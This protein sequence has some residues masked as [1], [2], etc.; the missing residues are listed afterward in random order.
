MD[1]SYRPLK[2][3]EREL[4]EKLLEPDFPGRDELLGQISSV[5]AKEIDEDGG[6]AL[7]C[8]PSRPAPVK[9]RVPTE[10]ECVDAD[11]VAIHVLL[12]VVDG[13]MSELEIFKDDS[14]RV[15]NPPVA[16]DLVLF[17]PYGEAGV[18]WGAREPGAAQS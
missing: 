16:R 1:L 11:G 8:A 14:S 5:T 9:C 4:L 7:Q 13:T 10:G 2:T 6:L 3:N 15:Q 18:K 12:H 17:T